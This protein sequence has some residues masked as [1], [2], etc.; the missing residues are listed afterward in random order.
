MSNYFKTRL[1]AEERL[2]VMH[3][4]L[5]TRSFNAALKDLGS[6]LEGYEDLEG[7]IK[8]VREICKKIVAYALKDQAKDTA[9][10]ILRQSRDFVI[11][12][13]RRSPVRKEQEV[14]MPISD[15]WQFVNVVLDSRCNIC[16]KSAAE[17]E[18]CPV[19]KLLR[20]YSDEPE[21]G[22]GNCGFTGCVVGQNDS[23]NEQKPI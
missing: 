10:I 8:T 18:A 6:K 16:L 23:T 2:G 1:R 19:R 15:E 22:Y 17:A 12:L 21:A 11:S 13:E 20:K 5:L 9:D 7:D 14:V 4:D 3:M